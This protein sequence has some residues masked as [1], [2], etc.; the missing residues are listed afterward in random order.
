M[1]KINKNKLLWK[2]AKRYI[3]TGNM[4]LSKNPSR[5]IDKIWPTYFS[6]S[7][8]C[9]V[10]DL[11]KKKYYDMS[12]MGVGT[13]I[14]GYANKK[15]D[16]KVKDVIQKGNLTTLNCP[17]EVLLAKQLIKMHPWSNM[18]RFAKTGGEANAIA[19]RL[20]R[21]FTNKEIVLVCGYHG[22]HDWYL[23]ANLENKNQLDTHLFKDLKFAGVPNS[24]KGVTKTFNYN[25]YDQLKKMINKYGNKIAA[26]KMEVQRDFIPKNNF[27]KKIRDITKKNKILLIFDEC[28]SGFRETFGGLHLKYRVNPDI[29]L[30][31]KALGNGYP[32]TA[33]IG[34]RK[35]MEMSKNT[36]ISSTFWTDRIG[37]TAAL[38]SLKEM[39]RVKSWKIISQKG[40]LIKE[41]L[42]EIGKK[43]NLKL[44]F[45]GLDSLITFEID[46]KNPEILYK[47][48]T[49]RMLQNG[50]LAKNAIYVCTQHNNKILNKYFK[51]MDQIFSEIKTNSIEILKRKTY[52][53]IND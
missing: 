15:V 11:N 36:F 17:E 34:K 38:A 9:E 16:T 20:A 39:Q 6:K 23:A 51:I 1:E 30:F 24:L 12:L 35:I 40:L 27:L 29:A 45:K 50:F 43:N 41:K 37:P 19:I 2:I 33:I 5:F 3:P 18:A 32:I 28:T 10:W 42:N 25:N 49:A 21:A 31:G 47:Y 53:L 4:F 13:N 44:H 7:K 26:V 46:S 22:W 14:L 8:G 48:I 52:K